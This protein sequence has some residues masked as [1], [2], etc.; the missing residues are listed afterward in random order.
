MEKRQHLEPKEQVRAGFLIGAVICLAAILMICT[1]CACTNQDVGPAEVVLQDSFIRSA[2]S[3]LEEAEL[4]YEEGNFDAA[5]NALRA[6]GQQEH[7]YYRMDEVLYWM[8]RCRYSQGKYDRADRAF[9]LLQRLYPRSAMDFQDLETIVQTNRD[10]LRSH[11]ELELA[12]TRP[13]DE[14]VSASWGGS[15]DRSN[16]PTVTNIFYETDVRQAITD[17]SAQT[18]V[19]IVPDAFVSGYVTV[20]FIETPLSLA[21]DQ[22]L[23][24]LGLSYRKMEN[25][26]LVGSLSTESPSFPLLS[27]SKIVRPKY[28]NSEEARKLMPASYEKFLRLDAAGNSLSITAPPSIIRKFEEDLARIDKPRTQVM[29]EALV[30]QVSSEARR[31]LGIDWGYI[32]REGSETYHLTKLSPAGFD[33]SFMMGLNKVTSAFDLQVRLRALAQRG[34]AKVRANPR[35]ATVDGHEA[36]IRIAREVYFSLVQGSVNFPY[37]TL[38]KIPTGISLK[39][40][41]HIGESSEITSDIHAEVSDVIGSG[42]SELPVTNVRIVDTRIRVMNGETIAI[43]G[44][45]S[46]SERQDNNRIPLLGDIPILGYL[47]GH[48]TTVREESEILILITPHIL[49]SPMELALL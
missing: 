49:I 46:E 18:G 16:E 4:Q 43:G 2:D 35:V 20:E 21:L 3:L 11:P 31:S 5:L 7:S 19:S 48:T 40:T 10:S 8:G 39:I 38:E 32:G 33:S 9:S 24:P 36:E 22:L 25:H 41:P 1:G 37:F 23:S 29:I 30:V 15:N 42:V 45:V 6:V 27:E 26:Y 14:N 12:S 44:L 17:I 28:L 34:Q 47:F 13:A